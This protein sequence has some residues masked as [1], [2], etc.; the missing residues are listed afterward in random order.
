MRSRLAA[1]LNGQG[2]DLG[3]G[4][5]PF[6]VPPGATVQLVDRLQPEE[7]AELL[8]ELAGVE[9]PQPD[10][11]ANFDTD[12]LSAIATESQDFVVCSHVLEHL[13][14]PLGM[15]TDIHRVLRPGGLALI[16][17]PDRRQTFDADRQP[18][19]IQHL[20]AEH[21]AG[22]TA[23]DDDHIETFLAET[24]DGPSPF[25]VHPLD[26]HR[27]RSIHAH[28]WAD[29]EFQAVLLY[30]VRHLRWRWHLID[31]FPTAPDGVE[32]GFLLQRSGGRS[33]RRIARRLVAAFSGD[34]ALTPP[35]ESQE[36]VRVD[37]AHQPTA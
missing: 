14:D 19:S 16:V 34:E 15:V 32:F 33:K 28:C 22:V 31:W 21:R 12:R 17:L 5:Q 23:V 11:I 1:Q 3:P 26:W 9:F 24:R 36:Q 8:P 30:G 6:A 4:H 7:T 13:A 10:V 27:Q 2:L 20:V 37:P 25:D 35:R 18:T 29:V